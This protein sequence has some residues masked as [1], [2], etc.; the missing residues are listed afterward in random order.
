M[1][2]GKHSDL[3]QI[4]IGVFFSVY[5][6]LGYG[7][8]EKVYENALAIELASQGIPVKQQKPVNV[9]YN[10]QRVGEY[11]ADLV[12]NDMVILELKAVR[13]LLPEHEAQLLNY[14]KATEME[15]GHL[16]NFGPKPHHIRKI[17][18][19]ERKG[20]LAWIKKVEDP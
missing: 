13:E 6:Q 3:T 18:D 16:L 1:F 9:Y 15:V 5:N 8:T 7:F 12:V 17:F 11:F 14:L 10:G 4:I 20:S 2:A 19:N